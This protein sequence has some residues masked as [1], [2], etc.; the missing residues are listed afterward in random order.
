MLK[1]ILKNCSSSRT[2]NSVVYLALLCL[3]Y[4][5]ITSN[6]LPLSSIPDNPIYESQVTFVEITKDNISTIKV[7]TNPD[8]L[9]VLKSRYNLLQDL[10]SGDKI[11]ISHG[12]VSLTKISALK[13]ISLGIHIGINTATPDDLKAI[14]GIGEELAIRIVG[15]RDANRKFINLDEL[16]NIEGIGKKKL[17]AIK[18]LT[19]LD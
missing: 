18:K 1:R 9:N 19:Y 16:D 6:Y 10:N 7:F 11:I 15:Y 2:N 8:E 13:R 17:K 5:F 3:L 14:P 4:F 12:E